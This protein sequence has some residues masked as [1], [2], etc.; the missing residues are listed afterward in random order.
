MQMKNDNCER[1]RPIRKTALLLTRTK[2][3]FS[4]VA[5]FAALQGIAAVKLMVYGGEG[6]KEFLGVINEPQY[7][8]DSIWN[9]HGTY[10]DK[11]GD[12]V[13]WNKY[14]MYGGSSGIYSPFNK[15]SSTPP[16]IVDAQGNFYG[17]LTTNKNKK[18]RANFAL[19]KLICY[20][21]SNENVNLQDA[22]D[23]VQ[24]HI[25]AP[26]TPISRDEITRSPSEERPQN[27]VPVTVGST[28]SDEV[29]TIG[30]RRNLRGDQDGLLR[31]N[32]VELFEKVKTCL[33]VIK[34]KTGSGTG[35]IIAMDDGVWLV[36]NEHVT[37]MGHPLTAITS[38]GRQ[39]EFTS[40][41]VFQVATNRDMARI[42]MPDDT[43]ALKTS[44]KIPNIGDPIWVFGNSAG[45]NVLTYLEGQI[46][47][48]GAY[49][50]EVDAQFVDGNS[51]SPILDGDGDVVGLATYA[52]LRKD[53]TDWVKAGTR[54]NEVRR[55]AVTFRDVK[56]ESVEWSTY[57]K[58]ALLLDACEEYRNF[59]L[60]ICFK[61]KE[62]VTDYDVKKT[63]LAFKSRELGKALSQL[64]SQDKKYIEA[65]RAYDDI[66]LRRNKIRSGSLNR[67]SEQSVNSKNRDKDREKLKCYYVRNCALRA[68]RD[69]VANINWCTARLRD[70]AFDLHEGFSYC[71]RAYNEF[72]RTYL[73]AYKHEFSR[74]YLPLE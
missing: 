14:G 37:R 32:N 23:L 26:V 42:K 57:S 33:V 55:Y 67:P 38:D 36:T 11:Y 62:L 64:I 63:G 31:N 66:S 13:I 27:N 71:V 1:F 73:D 74:S 24:E 45:G 19:A 2:L 52:T 15:F 28:D 21:G 8:V 5:F 61:N 39:I 35:S 9:V 34:G 3:L 65:Y 25:N 17:F 54:F 70:A 58:Q 60:P 12:K 41:V 30:R 48:V 20:V 47:G 50:I 7:G 72:N 10:G 6:H 46:N 51:G 18:P 44:K 59:L 43:F 68:G 22:Y 49:E 4:W 40:K 29:R 16:I 69:L 53:P 56:W